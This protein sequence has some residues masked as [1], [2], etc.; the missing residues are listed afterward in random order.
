MRLTC[1]SV[2]VTLPCAEDSDLYKHELF[3]VIYPVF[4]HCFMDL[5]A[6]GHIQEASELILLYQAVLA[7]MYVIKY[8]N[9]SQ[10][11][12]IVAEVGGAIGAAPLEAQIELFNALIDGCIEAVELGSLDVKLMMLDCFLEYITMDLVIGKRLD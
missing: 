2:C 12:L 4:I 9:E 3:C 1:E 8:G 10:V 5:V 6:K 7:I 11:D